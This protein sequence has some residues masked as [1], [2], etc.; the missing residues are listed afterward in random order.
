MNK[1]TLIIHLLILFLSTN[2][3]SAT[4][5]CNFEGFNLNL[6][7]NK[8]EMIQMSL[9]KNTTLVSSCYLNVISYDDGV[10]GASVNE[11]IRFTKNN[12][13]NIYDKIAEK[14]S[15]I[16]SGFIKIPINSN[17]SYVHIL[18]NHQPLI[19]KISK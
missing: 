19:C 11:L 9:I 1:N 8:S 16:D 17:I 6:R 15:I 13:K 3:Y 14:V 4:L 7:V 2:V 5:L 12:C 10:S 18:K